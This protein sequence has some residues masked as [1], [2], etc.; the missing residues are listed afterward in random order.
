MHYVSYSKNKEDVKPTLR[1]ADEILK[2]HH[3]AKDDYLNSSA[4]FQI[5]ARSSQVF[6]KRAGANE[7]VCGFT[8]AF[9]KRLLPSAPVHLLE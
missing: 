1:K 5:H 9:T 6:T 8:V 3:G 7:I 4:F 2:R